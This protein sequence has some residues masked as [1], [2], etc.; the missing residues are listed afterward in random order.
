MPGDCS[1]WD[2]F[3]SSHA[4]GSPF[5]LQAWRKSIEATFDYKSIYMLATD[6]ARIRAVLPLFLVKN[7]LVKKAL[8]SSPFAVY[9]GILADSPE[10]AA[11]LYDAVR[12]C[13]QE[14]GVEYIEL[15]NAYECQCV[16]TP[17]IS[18]YV[19]FTHRI[20]RSED[21]LLESIPRKTRYM[22]RK[23]LKQDYTVR[24]TRALDTFEA[25]YSENLRR[26]GTPAFPRRHFEALLRNFGN[27]V[28]IRE[29]HVGGRAIAAVLTFY[30]QDQILPYYGASDPVYNALAPNNL[31]YFDLMRSSSALGFRTFDFG[32]SKTGSGS[33]EFKAHWGMQERQLPYEMILIRRKTVPNFSPA[34]PVYEWPIRIW[35]RMPLRLTRALGPMLVRLVP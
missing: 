26:L 32:R 5:H 14:L 1:P 16:G 7:V 34:N 17:N 29:F 28:D 22:I 10:A 9:G 24:T 18:R 21:A 30:F 20:D 3:V 15:R 4:Q 19:T 25:L 8:I 33:Y 6:G 13:G 27:M 12:K 2:E 35:Q 23:S 31:M 11:V